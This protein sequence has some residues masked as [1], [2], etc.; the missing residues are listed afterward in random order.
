MR[1]MPHP[2]ALAAVLFALSLAW[3]APAQAQAPSAPA[4]DSGAPEQ[5]MLKP[6]PRNVKDILR[7]LETAK[8]D[9][10]E[11]EQARAL[12]AAPEPAASADN[13]SWNAYH[14]KRAIALQK[15]GRINEAL[16]DM[17]KAAIDRAQ[18]E[19]KMIVRDLIDLAVMEGGTGNITQAIKTLEQAKQQLRS[20]PQSGGFQFAIN[21]LLVVNQATLGNFEVAN[22]LLRDM[23]NLL[24]RLRRVPTAS[25]YLP[26]WE[27]N[28]ESARGTFFW[29]QGQ[30]VESE[31]ALRKALRLLQ[32]NYQAAKAHQNSVNDLAADSRSFSDGTTNPRVHLTQIILRTLNLADTLQQ[33]RKLID[34]EYYAR[35]A[36][37]L[38][39]DQFGRNS[40]EVG[41]ALTVMSKVVSEQGRFPEAVLLA[42]AALSALRESGLSDES[43]PMALSR[44]FYATA[45]VAEGQYQEAD[46][47]FT[48][49]VTHLAKDPSL[50][51]GFRSDDLDWVMAMQKIGKQAP[52][53]EMVTRMLRATEAQSGKNANRTAL[54]RAFQAVS[55]QNTGNRQ[56]AHAAFREAAPV[57]VDQARSDAE[58]DTA[59][60]KQQQRTTYLFENYLALLAR[61]ASSDPAQA[62][63]A[64]AE[65]F[66][67]ADLAKSSG[68]QRA[69]TASAA[70][71]NI[72]DPVL[73]DLARKEQDLQ[74]RV[75]SLSEL[76][77]GLL[78]APPEQQL[79][80][81]Q[82]KVR[83]DIA[84]FKT[85][86]EGLK[87][88]IERKYPDYAEM[89]EPKPATVERTRSLLR[90]DE[91]L[92]SWYFADQEAYVWAI[93]KN[94]I[95][96]FKAIPMGRRAMA[97]QVAL[98]RKALDPGVSTID[99]IPAF[100]V[101]SS[102]RLYQQIL[103]PVQ[104]SLKG[105]KVLL[106]VP[107]AE[108]GQL[109]LS[110]LVTQDVALAA[111]AIPF[112]AYRN[113]PWLVRDIAI[114]QLPSVTALTALRNTPPASGERKNFIGFG[115]P[116]FSADQA[117]SAER[118][119]P[120]T[121]RADDTQLATR[122]LPL[123]LRSAPKTA[124]VSSAELALLPRLPDTQEEIRE[125]AKVLS[126]APGDVLLN[127]QASVKAV[128]AADLSDRK[129]V[130]FA[131]HGLVPGEL[132]GLSQPA[133]AM[134]S[135]EVTG[136]K[137]DG[138]LTMDKV[139]T[140]KLNADWVVLS[141]CNTAAGEGSGSE[142]V[143]G[144]GRAFFF[145]GA[146]ALL[147]SNWPVDSAAARQ[148]MTDLFRRQQASSQ[149]LAK[150]EA[151]RQAMLQQLDQGGL[152]DR[153]VM[154]YSYAH[155][156]FWAPFVVVGD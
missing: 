12:L 30:W 88:E 92:V 32:Q 119:R 53:L 97:E 55:L 42:R 28:V 143:S 8:R 111:N 48:E 108:L 127:R 102:F 82:A 11:L 104:D 66:R 52:A 84:S 142:A 95:P 23:D 117:R 20:M 6:P 47:V 1:S 125:I 77:T 37:Q 78:A 17:R 67:V 150:S 114:A 2:R 76:L 14:F 64:A 58:N 81:V 96:L 56:G 135:P 54:V 4:A 134:S 5:D 151:L 94:D 33:Q 60:L 131:T 144:L 123:R 72:K 98:L 136:D 41:R 3:L 129:V 21:R 118:A 110:V 154:K 63:A 61:V 99:E 83:Q 50:A 22:Q 101:K 27:S 79:P 70:R 86:R 15:L 10:S 112:A 115:D 40:S 38:G 49:M 16:V 34:A 9:M 122:G 44:K 73:A 137:D 85:E 106:V 18:S 13:A 46:Q 75:N 113:L 71:A 140:L 152:L 93:G 139:L 128:M 89:V 146:R 7:V 74:R 121:A 65:A 105:K 149:P 156:L 51:S 153:K 147:V 39:L 26:Q 24:N 80:S 90:A 107:H 116:Y 138:L 103:A 100:D 132:D 141:A 68:V 35:E 29:M 145:A 43:R 130:M 19:P 25:T 120:G 59:S 31:R 69:L 45:L 87:K 126:A 148:L 62:Q 91:V 133:L 124:G 36:L 57:L 155:P 109:P